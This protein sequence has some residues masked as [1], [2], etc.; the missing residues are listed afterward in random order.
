MPEIVGFHIKTDI[1]LFMKIALIVV[2]LVAL[3]AADQFVPISKVPYGFTIGDP[4]GTLHI[5]A[6]YDLLCKKHTM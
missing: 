6:F 2:T 5:Q 1:N 4:E 3:T